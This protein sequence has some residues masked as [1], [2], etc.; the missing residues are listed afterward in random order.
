MNPLQT[1]YF[2]WLL[3]CIWFSSNF[4]LVH[5]FQLV[6][7]RCFSSFVVKRGCHLLSKY[8]VLKKLVVKSLLLLKQCNM[9][10]WISKFNFEKHWMQ[11]DEIIH[12]KTL[13]TW[14]QKSKPF[15]ENVCS[16]HDNVY[17]SIF[18]DFT[19]HCCWKSLLF[20]LKFVTVFK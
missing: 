18:I 9:T 14:R 12:F 3:L 7:N 5:Y 11:N 2:A 1:Y 19:F 6:S 20:L 8:L 10:F 15:D 13:K 4:R 17:C 16:L